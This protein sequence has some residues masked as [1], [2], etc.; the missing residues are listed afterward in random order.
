MKDYIKLLLD[1]KFPLKIE[2]IEKTHT[3][4]GLMYLYKSG[5]KR[6]FVKIS[7]QKK[8]YFYNYY[9]LNPEMLMMFFEL[10]YSEAEKKL[11]EW[12]DNRL[13]KQLM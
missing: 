6:L 13:E 7:S 10:S 8:G 9:N 5:D 2:V 1:K 4:G 12:V 3:F 11:I